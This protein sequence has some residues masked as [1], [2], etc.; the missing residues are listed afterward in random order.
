M[1]ICRTLKQ[2]GADVLTAT[3]QALR[4]C[5]AD[6]KLPRRQ[7]IP[8]REPDALRSTERPEVDPPA[9]HRP[10]ARGDDRS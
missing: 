10:P 9:S 3:E 7:P 1:S 8:L 2:R 6:G 5:M 4:T